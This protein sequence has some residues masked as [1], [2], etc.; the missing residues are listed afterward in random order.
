LH[1]LFTINYFVIAT[2]N[3]LKKTAGT[4]TMHLIYAIFKSK[5]HKK[6]RVML[7]LIH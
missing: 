1:T 4:W 2:Q 3:P 5:N 6:K 7:L